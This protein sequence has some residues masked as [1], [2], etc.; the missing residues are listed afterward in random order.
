MLV[1][2]PLQLHAAR[3]LKASIESKAI[4]ESHLQLKIHKTHGGGTQKDR[5]RSTVQLECRTQHLA[6][7]AGGAGELAYRWKWKNSASRL[8]ISAAWRDLL[9]NDEVAYVTKL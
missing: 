4:Q 1:I 5:Y 7:K 9:H 3:D 2:K 8:H 6:Q